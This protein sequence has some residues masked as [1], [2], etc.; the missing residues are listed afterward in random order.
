MT[1]R[2]KTVLAG[3][4]LTLLAAPAFADDGPPPP[5]PGMEPGGGPERIVRHFLH[6]FDFDHDGKI[7]RAEFD[8]GSAERFKRIDTD[9]DGVITEDE[10]R[11]MPP[12]RMHGGPMDHDGPPPPP[13]G[14]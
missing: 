7:A 9:G 3:T 6:D 2:L 8:R 1:S 5:P 14:N 10:L 11:A 4:A 13:P 12:P